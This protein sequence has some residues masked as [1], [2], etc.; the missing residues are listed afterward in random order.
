MMTEFDIE[1]LRGGCGFG[2]MTKEVTKPCYCAAGDGCW[3][4][5]FVTAK[6]SP[7]HDQQLRDVTLAIKSMLALLEPPTANHHLALANTKQGVILIWA[8]HESTLRA[9]AVTFDNSPEEIAEA[10][11]LILEES[12]PPESS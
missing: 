2:L 9:D 10:F 6:I 5:R 3:A 1:C 7:F 8:K 4:A 11:Q 12:Q